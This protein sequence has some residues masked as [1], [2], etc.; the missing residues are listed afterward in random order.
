[1]EW[2]Y[3]LDM[4]VANTGVEPTFV[5]G[6]TESF[7][8]ATATTNEISNCVSNW[9]VLNAETLTEHKYIFFEVNGKTRRQTIGSKNTTVDCQA[10][11][12]IIQTV[13]EASG[14][15]D[16]TACT[17]LIRHAYKSTVKTQRTEINKPYWWN[18]CID[19]KRKECNRLRRRLTRTARAQGTNT[20]LLEE[21]RRAYKP[22]K[23]ELVNT[24]KQSKRKDLCSEL[25]ENIWG[26]AYK[27]IAKKFNTLVP[28]NLTTE[29]KR[30]M[31]NTLFHSY[32][33]A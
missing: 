27:I 6:E 21:N 5:R 22:A 18:D 25:D 7:F 4:V 17:N 15:T 19:E 32:R 14:I 3:E 28:Y 30:Q 20:Q 11:R 29:K 2:F 10:F 24:I 23:R 12:S 13:T 1:M 33:T 26:D 8:D 9:R 16:H 31:L